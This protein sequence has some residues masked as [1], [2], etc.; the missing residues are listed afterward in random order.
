MPLAKFH[1]QAN[2]GPEALF[3]DA[4][5]QKDRPC[6]DSDGVEPSRLAAG[7]YVVHVANC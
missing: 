7:E 2:D 3:V 5:D 1:L 4:P 6:T